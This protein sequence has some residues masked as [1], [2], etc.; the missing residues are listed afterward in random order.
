[1]AIS[2]A[3][4]NPDTGVGGEGPTRNP[5]LSLLMSLLNIRLGYWA[6]HPDPAINKWQN[7][8]HQHEKQKMV[9]M[10][11][12]TLGQIVPTHSYRPNFFVPMLSATAFGKF[13]G[14][15][16]SRL[17]R[18]LPENFQISK[19]C[20]GKNESNHFIELTDGGHFENLG[21][22]ELVRRRLK[23][24][25]VLDGAADPKFEFADLANAME[26]VRVDFGVL[27]KLDV[28]PMI[29]ADA[30]DAECKVNCAEQGF[31]FGEIVYPDDTRGTLVYIKTAYVRGLHPDLLSYKKRHA[32][33]P[34]Q[35]TADQFFDEKQFEAYRE[36]G[37]SLAKMMTIS[38]EGRSLLRDWIRRDDRE[39]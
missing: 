32:D 1:M 15:G 16:L 34:D 10:L 19:N 7:W 6:P 33:F 18:G 30:V 29:P 23:L 8:G 22:Y 21:I 17:T 35:T 38:P 31:V 37:Y 13:I 9:S 27:L 11:S 4:A 2:G 14:Y 3:A 20:F 5:V 25:I 12:R 36:L 39:I 24:I 26:K 28:R